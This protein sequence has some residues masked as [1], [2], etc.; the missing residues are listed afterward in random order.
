MSIH[1]FT[2]GS[3]A[4]S[5]GGWGVL[6]TGPAGPKHYSGA[7]STND[8]GVSEV[9]G[10]LEAVRRAPLGCTLTVVTDSTGTVQAVRTG[11]C[12]NAEIERLAQAVRV[13]ADLREIRL[14]V[15][16]RSREVRG[17][18]V[19]HTLAN[20]GR[21]GER[22]PLP[23]APVREA[24]VRPHPLRPTVTVQVQSGGWHTTEEI[25]GDEGLDAPLMAALHLVRRATAGEVLRL[26]LESPLTRA[27]LRG[28]VRPRAP[29]VRAA[30]HEI[31]RRVNGRRLTLKVN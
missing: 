29:A 20:A 31:T 13:T 7:L 24:I 27:Y 4:R 3:T 5:R 21:K 23:G 11:R 18:K 15:E 2:D 14:T 16:H 12:R 19:A 26:T 8:N 9:R 28:E 10:V 22:A 17:L 1:A 25:A 6:I 30:L